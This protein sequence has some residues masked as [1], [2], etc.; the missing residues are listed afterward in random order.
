MSYAS[1]MRKTRLGSS[2]SGSDDSVAATETEYQDSAPSNASL[3]VSDLISS[4][5]Q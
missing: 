4:V 2:E 5:E 1:R 3:N